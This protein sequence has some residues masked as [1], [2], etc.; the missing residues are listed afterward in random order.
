MAAAPSFLLPVLCCHK[1]GRA[2]FPCGYSPAWI[3]GNLH[4]SGRASTPTTVTIGRRCRRREA[5]SKALGPTIHTRL[6]CLAVPSIPLSLTLLLSSSALPGRPTTLGIRRA[7]AQA[8]VRQLLKHFPP[9]PPPLQQQQPPL[10]PI[11]YE[12]HPYQPPPEPNYAPTPN[13]SNS[14]TTKKATRASQVRADRTPT[15]P[16][17]RQA[18]LTIASHRPATT[19]DSSRP[20]ATRRNRARRA[21]IR[22][23]NVCTEIRYP[24]RPSSPAAGEPRSHWHAL[25][26]GQIPGRH[27]GWHL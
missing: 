8:V 11:P 27:S 17:P 9:P 14:N 21:G 3:Q 5:L 7:R 25:H 2:L 4:R 19:S 15:M 20:G 13:T 1:Q 6:R 26:V 16:P 10:H 24:S 22:A 12:P 23:A 18:S